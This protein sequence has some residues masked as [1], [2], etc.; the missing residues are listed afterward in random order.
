MARDR[1]GVKPFYY[2]NPDGLFVFASEQ[3]SILASGMLSRRL[4]RNSLAG[5]LQFQSAGYPGMLIEGIHEL[6]PGHFAH[7]KAGIFNISPYWKLKPEVFDTGK[8]MDQVQLKKTLFHLLNDAVASRM[9]SSAPTGVFLSG[10]V[11]SSA[12]T[13]IMSLHQSE[14]VNTFTLHLDQN[15]LDEAVSAAEFAKLY[16][17]RHHGIIFNPVD[18]QLQ[19]ANFLSNL[20]SPS[21]DG[22]NTYL[23]S[24]A[25][26]NAGMKVMLSGLGGDELFAGYPG[27]RFAK[28][29]QEYKMIFD[30]SR[31]F[32][33]SI[34]SGI[35]GINFFGAFPLFRLLSANS[36]KVSDCYPAFRQVMSLAEIRKYLRAEENPSL[37]ITHKIL[38]FEGHDE[39]FQLGNYSQAEYAYYAVNT[40]LR[41]ND[42]AGMANSIE[43]R[44]PLFDYKLVE[45]VCSLPDKIKLSCY[46]KQL[47]IDA[48]HPL[49]PRE[50]N[51]RKKKGF[52]LPMENWMRGDLRDLCEKSI[53]SLGERDFIH[54]SYLINAW[55]KFLTR[56]SAVRWTTIW[57]FVVLGA[58]MDKNE[59]S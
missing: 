47:L 59:V 38:G 51:M 52:V 40:L 33:K 45:F 1:L 35:S 16:R 6:P 43:I 50:I 31:L 9:L 29:L 58:W 57:Q 26:A 7:F 15:G 41:D 17:C 32:R 2:S 34:A 20:D 25:A 14:P 27:F 56:R 44:E 4:N 36:H 37:E 28:K 54:R 55:R 42:Q 24:S 53:Y 18:C 12:I 3:R 21:M 39:A 10:G 8:F 19:V 30:Y 49:L 5:Y 11:D 23:I 13:A 22:L 46:P 48:V